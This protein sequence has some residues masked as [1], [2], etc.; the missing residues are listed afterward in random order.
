ML[1]IGVGNR[2][3]GDDA[4]GPAVCDLLAELAPHVRT[5]VLEGD[6][7][8]LPARWSP[9]DDVVIIDA[10]A[11]AGAPGRVFEVDAL[12][13][14]LRTP[15]AVSTHGVDVGTAIELARAMG[16]LPQSL[17]VIGIEAAGDDHGAPLTPEVAVSVEHVA[18]HLAAA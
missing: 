6:V 2:D 15:A 5:E 7:L 17:R 16:A 4:A 1:V 9:D 14:R 10:A 3:R 12:A 13:D 18:R 11:P 8:D